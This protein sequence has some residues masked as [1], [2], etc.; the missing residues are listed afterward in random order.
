MSSDS[1]SRHK[2]DIEQKC[3]AVRRVLGG[4]NANRV[5]AELQVSRDRLDRWERYFLKGG[6]EGI[7]KHHERSKWF[8]IRWRQLLPWGGLLL[9]LILSV[10]AASRFLQPPE[11]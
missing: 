5:A 10:Y 1:R 2:F 6:Q 4:E 8:H 9:L 11:P 3:A 7:A